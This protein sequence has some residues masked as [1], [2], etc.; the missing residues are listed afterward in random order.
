MVATA[1]AHDSGPIAFRYPRGNGTGIALPEKPQILEI[2]KGRMIREGSGEV[3]LLSLGTLLGDC[4]AAA[5]VLA[6]DGIDVTLADA[7]FAKPLDM[8]LIA[9]LVQTHKTLIL[10]EQGMFA[11]KVTDV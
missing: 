11:P 9:R 6:A 8:E 5:T 7:R 4:E 1:A 10:L 3:V 2:G